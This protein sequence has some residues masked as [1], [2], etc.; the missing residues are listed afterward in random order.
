VSA[1]YALS[2]SVTVLTAITHSL[3]NVRIMRYYTCPTL[4]NKHCVNS[5][6]KWFLKWRIIRGI[7]LMKTENLL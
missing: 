7:A 4:R 1:G 5:I 2:Q 3:I 6:Y